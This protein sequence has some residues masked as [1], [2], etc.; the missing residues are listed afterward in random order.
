M[1]NLTLFLFIIFVSSL[2]AQSYFIPKSSERSIVNRGGSTS[3]TASIPFQGYDEEEAFFGQ[4]E[5]E[6]FLDV[7]DG[8]LDNPIIVLDGFDPG[9]S[10]DITGL[11]NRLEFGGENLADVV[12]E[13]GYDIVILNAPVYS[14]GGVQ[15]DGGADFI[16]RNAFVLIELIEFLNQQKE[17]DEELV[18]LGPSMGGLIAQYALSYMEQND[19]EHQTRLFISFDSPHRGANIPVSLQYLINFLAR[20]FGDETAVAVVENVLNSAAAKEMLVDHYLGHLADGSDTDQDPDKLL[21][22]GAPDFRDAFQSELDALGFPQNVRNVAM[23][24]GSGNGTSTGTSGMQVVST[25][26]DLGGSITADVTLRFT[27]PAS[28]TNEVTFFE[29]FLIGVPLIDFSAD[30][31][32]SSETDGVD[33]APGGTSMISSALGDGQGNQVIIDFIEALDQDL[34]CFIPTIS[35]LAIENEP[36]WYASPDIGG[37]HNSPFVNFYIPD[38]NE[39]HVTVTEESAA[40]ALEEILETTLGQADLKVPKIVLAQNPIRGPI[41]LQLGQVAGPNVNIRILDL[42]GK[43][44]MNKTILAN[45]GMVRIPHGLNSGMYLLEVNDGRTVKTIKLMVR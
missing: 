35:A 17:G 42:S 2:S 33:A 27:P 40:F 6:I 13:E 41:E 20:E 45:P 9:D 11:Y 39:D 15:I 25:E 12:R 5:Y 23:I 4:G 26:L 22:G 34:F 28:Q 8:I 14:T 31:E 29:G 30:S 21:P 3:I 7:V 24:N 37:I 38:S 19:M 36:N 44:L 32:S 18:V 1:K 10:R 16:Q 43:L